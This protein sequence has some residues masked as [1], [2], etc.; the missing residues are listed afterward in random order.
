MDIPVSLKYAWYIIKEFWKKKLSKLHK[1]MFTSFIKIRHRQIMGEG[2]QTGWLVMFYLSFILRDV[3]NFEAS[4]T[5]KRSPCFLSQNFW[6]PR[7]FGRV[8]F[9]TQISWPTNFR[10]RF[11]A[12]PNFPR[13]SFLLAPRIQRDQIGRNVKKILNHPKTLEWANV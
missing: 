6:A 8:I 12:R 1:I 2:L 9:R 4:P 7:V 11:S 3:P 13:V 10:P 5:F